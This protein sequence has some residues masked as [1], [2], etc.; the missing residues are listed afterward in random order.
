[1][2]HAH[3]QIIIIK[4]LNGRP[5]AL[6]RLIDLPVVDDAH[7]C[8]RQIRL[9]SII[10]ALIDLQLPYVDCYHMYRRRH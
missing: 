1:M 10:V 6:N 5:K 8:L 2:E 3:H 9:Q 4:S 7:R